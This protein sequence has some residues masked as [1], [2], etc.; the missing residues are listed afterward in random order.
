MS[1]TSPREG[2]HPKE[3]KDLSLQV[4]RTKI[5]CKFD[6]LISQTSSNIAEI[7]QLTVFQTELTPRQS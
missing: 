5:Y 7:N 2:K 6:N 4:S 1:E 3:V